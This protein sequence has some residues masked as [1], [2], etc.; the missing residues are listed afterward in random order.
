MQLL[1]INCRYFHYVDVYFLNYLRFFICFFAI[2]KVFGTDNELIGEQ[3]RLD[4]KTG[5]CHF[6]MFGI[7]RINRTKFS[8]LF[9]NN[10]E[11]RYFSAPDEP[12]FKRTMDIQK[13][14]PAGTVIVLK[15]DPE[16]LTEEECNQFKLSYFYK[17]QEDKL[18]VLFSEYLENVESE[19]LVFC[20]LIAD[21][22]SIDNSINELTIYA[23]FNHNDHAEFME[24][25][26][27]KERGVVTASINTFD[28]EISTIERRMRRS[29]TDSS[30]MRA[31]QEQFVK[32][33]VVLGKMQRTFL[34]LQSINSLDCNVFT[35]AF[36]HLKWAHGIDPKDIKNEKLLHRAMRNMIEKG[37][38]F[39]SKSKTP[40]VSVYE[41]LNRSIGTWYCAELDRKTNT[42]S[43]FLK[44]SA[45]RAMGSFLGSLA[46]VIDWFSLPSRD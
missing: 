2:V 40:L 28:S 39:K 33:D 34:G 4:Q 23:P 31:I 14:Y 44:L 22:F 30:L 13:E 12:D 15:A 41:L 7:S 24:M 46:H 45:Y 6:T 32:K 17:K 29:K 36:L 8:E 20:D 9:E 38:V 18:F 11:I 5:H 27:S 26:C 10:S 3:L 16:F 42:I 37:V 21:A 1:Y 19:S 25:F 43:K 35:A